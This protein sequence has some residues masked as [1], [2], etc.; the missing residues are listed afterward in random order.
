[1]FFLFFLENICCGYSLEVPRWRTS[2]EYPQ[3]MFSSRNKKNI[4]DFWLKKSSLCGTVSHLTSAI[5]Y[6]TY[7]L[8]PEHMV[9]TQIKLLQKQFSQVCLV[10]HIAGTFQTH[11]CMK[12]PKLSP[13]K[14][15]QKIHQEYPFSLKD[16]CLTLVLLNK[17]RCHTL[18]L[19]F[20]QSDYLIQAVHA[21]SNPEWQTVQIKIS[22]LLHCLQRQDISGFKRT[23][24]KETSLDF[25]ICAIRASAWQNHN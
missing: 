17:L 23:K 4:R 16:I 12:S 9:H 3:H 22:W 6:P 13:L 2:N 8:I 1:M 21:N 14:K 7:S 19:I 20:S 11:H 24:V 15:W 18:L 10:C 5:S 25:N